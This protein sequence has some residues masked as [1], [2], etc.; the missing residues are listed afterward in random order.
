MCLLLYYFASKIIKNVKNRRVRQFNFKLRVKFI[1]DL[2]WSV[3]RSFITK[4]RLFRK[5]LIPNYYI[6]LKST[7]T[8]IKL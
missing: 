3:S 7:T 4:V 5:K 8:L 1:I 2:N 6:A